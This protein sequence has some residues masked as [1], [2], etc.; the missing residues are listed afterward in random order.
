MNSKYVIIK[1]PHDSKASTKEFILNI[2]KT[3]VGE[4]VWF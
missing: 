2:M 1:C 4:K 3:R